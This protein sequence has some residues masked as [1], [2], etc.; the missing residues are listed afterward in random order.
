MVC[1]CLAQFDF[2][3]DVCQ[4]TAQ[5]SQQRKPS[6]VSVV[7]FQGEAQIRLCTCMSLRCC[8]ISHSFRLLRDIN[9]EKQI[10][11]FQI[12]AIS[13]IQPFLSH[14]FTHSMTGN[15]RLDF[16]K[17]ASIWV[18]SRQPEVCKTYVIQH[19]PSAACWCCKNGKTRSK[20]SD[21]HNCRRQPRCGT[22][23]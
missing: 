19:L 13:H 15:H 22:G 23:G 18:S 6:V 17:L 8:W 12:S 16:S 10:R 11:Y 4:A 5:K 20:E 1:C 3:R 21:T 9:K 7:I 14:R 2:W